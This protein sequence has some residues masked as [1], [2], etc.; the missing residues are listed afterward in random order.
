[1]LNDRVPKCTYRE[2]LIRAACPTARSTIRAVIQP[3]LPG[4]SSSA[5]AIADCQVRRNRNSDWVFLFVFPCS[6]TPRCVSGPLVGDWRTRFWV[7][8]WALA[9]VTNAT[10]FLKSP[11]RA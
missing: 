6:G 3:A 11:A 2:P 9:A 4:S 5:S 10:A 1:M 7:C 8:R